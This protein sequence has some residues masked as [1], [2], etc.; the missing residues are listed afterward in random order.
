VKGEHASVRREARYLLRFDDLCPTVSRERWQN[1]RA[2][3]EEFQIRPILAVIPDNHDAELRV[4]PPNPEFWNQLRAMEADGATIGLHGYRHLCVS[5][6]RG[7]VPLSRMSEFAGVPADT[8]RDWIC[9]GLRILRKRGL[10]PKIWIAPRHGFDPNTLS[11]L[12]SEGIQL[13]SDGFAERPF[14]RD[15]LVWI[16]QQIWEPV[17]KREGL[18]TIC[19]HPNA[20]GGRELAKLHAFLQKHAKQFTSIE[21]A[22]AE[23][24][25]GKL[26]MV[27]HV[28]AAWILWRTRASRARRDLLNRPEKNT[29]A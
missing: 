21:R 3:I 20:A 8:Q 7:L 29:H 4:S 26:G 25:S 15:G 9:A 16:P 23:F 28:R 11:A 12:G 14:L 1:C 17:E 18:W 10:D 24:P 22:L 13:L 19:M 5:E 6:G 27:E 2:L